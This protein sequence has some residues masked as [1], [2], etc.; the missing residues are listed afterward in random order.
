[1]GAFPAAALAG[2]ALDLARI[3]P[4]PMTAVMSLAYLLRLLPRG[5]KWIH[6]AAPALSY[7]LVM[8]L[9]G[10]WD[11]LPLPGLMLGGVGAFLVPL[12]GDVSHRRGETGVAQVRLANP[13]VAAQCGRNAD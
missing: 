1:M 7:L 11:V 4:V 9:C 12:K 3:T 2:L 6:C 8:R 13:N 10:A 5:K